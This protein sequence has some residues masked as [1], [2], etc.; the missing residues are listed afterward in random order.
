MIYAF[1]LEKVE[2]APILFVWPSAE[3]EFLF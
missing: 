1:P 3:S 2:V